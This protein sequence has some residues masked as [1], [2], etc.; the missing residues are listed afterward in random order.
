MLSSTDLFLLNQEHQKHMDESTGKKNP[1]VAKVEEPAQHTNEHHEE[2][3]NDGLEITPIDDS[4]LLPYFPNTKPILFPTALY[5]APTSDYNIFTD[6][7]YSQSLYHLNFAPP[8][9]EYNPTQYIAPQQHQPAHQDRDRSIHPSLAHLFRH[10][11]YGRPAQAPFPHQRNEPAP[12]REK[13]KARTMT[14]YFNSEG[15]VSA[16][17]AQVGV[18]EITVNNV[19]GLS[20]LCSWSSYETTGG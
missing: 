11:P 15:V 7:R 9:L 18:Y 13:G 10:D 12:V 4:L 1:V 3:L 8:H 19:Q 5:P 2:D 20:M 17:Y 16:V 14:T 6:N